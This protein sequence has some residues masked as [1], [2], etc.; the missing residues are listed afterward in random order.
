MA[1]HCRALIPLRGLG[2]IGFHA[3][4]CGIRIAEPSLGKRVSAM[5]G[6]MEPAQCQLCIAQAMPALVV[7]QRQGGLG[8]GIAVGGA[9]R[10]QR[11]RAFPVGACG[12]PRS[13]IWARRHVA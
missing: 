9:F 2:Q 12:S 7:P 13:S 6:A 11:H 8:L 5:S 1:L 10:E 4:P 3:L